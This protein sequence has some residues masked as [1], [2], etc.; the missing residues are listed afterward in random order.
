MFLATAKQ[1]KKKREEGMSSP[2]GRGGI[3]ASHRSLRAHAA[4][5]RREKKVAASSRLVTTL[6]LRACII[7]VAERLSTMHTR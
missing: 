5:N 7:S 1:R 6:Y 4:I 3:H 2:V